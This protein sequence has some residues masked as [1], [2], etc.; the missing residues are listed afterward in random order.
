MKFSDLSL[1]IRTGLNQPNL[2]VAPGPEM[3]DTAT[4]F[5]VLTKTSGPGFETEML[6]DREGWQV[7]AVGDQNDYDDG[8][9]LATAID[10]LLVGLSGGGIVVGGKKVISIYRTAGPPTPLLRDDAERHHFVC[11]YIVSVESNVPNQGGPND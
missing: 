10:V 6:I 11:S 1:L 9:S 3:P 5:V 8:E 2:L 7:R 4:R